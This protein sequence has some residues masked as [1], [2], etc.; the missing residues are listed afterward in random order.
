MI[1]ICH[2]SAFHDNYIWMILHPKNRRCL[3]VDPGD[4]TPVLTTLEEMGLTLEGI[5][6]TH[7]HPDHTSG[8]KTLHRHTQAPVYGPST[9]RIPLLKHPLHDGDTLTFEPLELTLTIMS[10]PGHTR[11]H[12]AYYGDEKLFCGDTLFAAGCGRLFEGTAEQLY[13]SLQKIAT[14]PPQTALYCAHEYTKKNLRFAQSI[15]PENPAIAQRLASVIATRRANRP[16]IPSRLFEEFETNPFLRCHIP[17][18]QQAL[19]EWT[20]KTLNDPIAAFATLRALKD[21]F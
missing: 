15:E 20:G 19:C 12:I 5:L 21:A 14:L 7:H 3:V 2:L 13:Q 6:I 18:V 10:V 11:G 17:T 16:T 8:I 1:S 4:A 9:E